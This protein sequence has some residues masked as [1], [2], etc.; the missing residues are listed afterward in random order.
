MYDTPADSSRSSSSGTIVPPLS[1]S[2]RTHPS[3]YQSPAYSQGW[4]LSTLAGA[5]VWPSLLPRTI[6]SIV[7]QHCFDSS[8]SRG[9][10]RGA[11]SSIGQVTFNPVARPFPASFLVSVYTQTRPLPPRYADLSLSKR[12]PRE[13]QTRKA[14]NGFHSCFGTRGYCSATLDEFKSPLGASPTWDSFSFESKDTAL[15]FYI[16]LNETQRGIPFSC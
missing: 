13:D 2:P 11:H 16:V 7:C 6:P 5:T 4:P 10:F 3:L 14:G 9:L 12:I 8:S 15:E 1:A